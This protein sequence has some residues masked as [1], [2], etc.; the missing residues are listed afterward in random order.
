MNLRVSGQPGGDEGRKDGEMRPEFNWGDHHMTTIIYAGIGSRATPR[1]VLA[2]MTVIVSGL[3]LTGWP[4]VSGGAHPGQ[5]PAAALWGAAPERGHARSCCGAA[6]P[7]AREADHGEQ[8][9]LP[10]LPALLS[11]PR[12][13]ARLR[14]GAIPAGSSRNIR[15]A[16]ASAFCRSRNSTGSAECSPSSNPRHSLDERGRGA[17]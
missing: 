16:A 4:L 6:L 3:A 17:C 9:G 10:A 2:D 12:S 5:V 8:G 11:P 14:P 15:R 7:A 13:R 1:P